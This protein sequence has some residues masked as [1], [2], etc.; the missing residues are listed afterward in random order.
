VDG[1]E[2]VVCRWFS[3]LYGKIGDLP[4]Q[5]ERERRLSGAMLPPEANTNAEYDAGEPGKFPAEV[6]QE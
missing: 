1:H 3:T 6:S 2:T 5:E 4:A